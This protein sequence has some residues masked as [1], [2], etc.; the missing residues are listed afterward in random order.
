MN[1]ITLI[2]QAFLLPPGEL[3]NPQ[4]THSR[5]KKAVKVLVWYYRYKLKLSLKEV[6]RLTGV[7]GPKCTKAV[8]DTNIKLREN[9][10]I[11]VLTQT[12]WT[13]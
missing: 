12:L 6:E 2:E 13:Y 9:K 7:S 8:Q 10:R 3:L 11:K 5:K 1:H 4:C